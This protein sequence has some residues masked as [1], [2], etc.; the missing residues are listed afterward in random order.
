MTDES[1]NLYV[2]LGARQ[3]Q[4]LRMWAERKAS[5]IHNGST[6]GDVLKDILRTLAAQ[7]PVPFNP[8]VGDVVRGNGSGRLY[9]VIGRDGD[10]LWLKKTESADGERLQRNIRDMG[11]TRS[12][13]KFVF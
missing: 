13:D 8:Q 10:Q 11:P 2:Q 7:L 3:Q 1:R 12:D 9:R 4:Y 5:I 6:E